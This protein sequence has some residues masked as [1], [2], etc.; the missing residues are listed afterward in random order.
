MRVVANCRKQISK[1][2]LK[3]IYIISNQLSTTTHYT[4][5]L[6]NAVSLAFQ[7]LNEIRT[8]PVCNF[9][10]SAEELPLENFSSFLNKVAGYDVN[11]FLSIYTQYKANRVGE[12]RH[13]Q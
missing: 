10:I 1:E 3:I 9:I 5:Q 6:L 12:D 2:L 4:T 8:F 11:A 7:E 13:F